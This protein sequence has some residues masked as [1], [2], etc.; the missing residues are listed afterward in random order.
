MYRDDAPGLENFVPALA[1]NSCLNMP[2]A[3]TQPGASTLADRG[4]EIRRAQRIGSVSVN[5]GSSASSS[6]ILICI[7]TDYFMVFVFMTT[8]DALTL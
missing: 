7:G 8:L 5:P 6:R 2:A 1:Y 3:F 4:T